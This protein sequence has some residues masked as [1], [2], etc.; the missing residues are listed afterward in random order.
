MSTVKMIFNDTDSSCDLYISPD[1][2]CEV[3]DKNQEIAQSLKDEL[4]SNMTQWYLGY[5]WGLKM[6]QPDG[7]GIFDKKGIT[8]SDI[9]QEIHRVMSKNKDILRT[10]I[11]SLIREDRKVSINIE[12]ETKHGNAEFSIALMGGA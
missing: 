8:D 4:E 11:T 1:G 12:I 9:Q 7:S 6:L 5:Y 3:I 10:N 2:Y